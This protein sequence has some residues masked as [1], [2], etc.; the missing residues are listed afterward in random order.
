[1]LDKART[2]AR[3]IADRYGFTGR[4]RETFLQHVE[5]LLEAA[6]GVFA[7]SEDME[8][9]DPN[10][11]DMTRAVNEWTAAFFSEHQIH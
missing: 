9:E 6:D 2:V 3:T 11:F 10:D 5:D 7:D 4:R 1:M 8:P